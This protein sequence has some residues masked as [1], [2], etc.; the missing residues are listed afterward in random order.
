[1]PYMVFQYPHSFEDKSARVAV[2]SDDVTQ[3][4]IAHRTK[5][6]ALAA[7]NALVPEGENPAAYGGYTVEQ[8]TPGPW[9]VEV[10]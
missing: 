3:A 2:E 10:E 8:I 1:M 5:A 9:Y 7:M 6:G 4:P